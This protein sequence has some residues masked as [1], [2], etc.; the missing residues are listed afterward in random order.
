MIETQEKRKMQ[1]ECLPPAGGGH[2]ESVRENQA[3]P[4]GGGADG[5]GRAR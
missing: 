4:G 2:R 1:T 3:L 5:G